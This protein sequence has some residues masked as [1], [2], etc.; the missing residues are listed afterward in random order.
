M[1][2]VVDKQIRSRMM[3]RI[4]CKDTKPEIRLRKTL[5]A[6]AFRLQVHNKRLRRRLDITLPKWPVTIEVHG[7]FWHR[8]EG[9]RYASLHKNGVTSTIKASSG[10][11]QRLWGRRP[12]SQRKFE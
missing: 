11:D 12:F 3:A 7:C 8:H 5:Q 2:A 1:A 6:M 4:R 9:C 10:S